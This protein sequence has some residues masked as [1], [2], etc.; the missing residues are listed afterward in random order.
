VTTPFEIY[1]AFQQRLQRQDYAGLGDVVDLQGYTENCLGLTGWTTGFE[2]ALQNYARNVLAPF[3]ELQFTPID[4]VEGS[5]ALVVR[6]RAEAIHS[7]DFL[8][9][10]ATGRRIG[11]DVVVMAHVNQGRV[12]GQW[13]QFDL[14]GIYQQLAAPEAEPPTPKAAVPAL[15]WARSA[16]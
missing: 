5:Q 14:W 9:I 2:A 16:R 13:I 12:A 11:W 6:N 8:G 1:S 7:G 3:S 15:P 10:P 4:V